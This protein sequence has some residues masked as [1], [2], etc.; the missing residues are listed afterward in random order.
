MKNPAPPTTVKPKDAKPTTTKAGAAKPIRLC[1]NGSGRGL[2][3]LLD[4][5]LAL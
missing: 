2:G 4:N 5:V 3:R 1:H